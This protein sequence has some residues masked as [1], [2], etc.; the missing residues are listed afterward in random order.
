MLRGEPQLMATD[1]IP[2]RHTRGRLGARLRGRD[3][4]GRHCYAMY[5]V[6]NSHS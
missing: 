6:P 4:H 3:N 5:I 2:G 1:K